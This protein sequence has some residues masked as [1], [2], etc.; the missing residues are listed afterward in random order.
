M[1]VPNKTFPGSSSPA[2]NHAPG[3]R[4][5]TPL[6]GCCARAEPSGQHLT[7]AHLHDSDYALNPRASLS[8]HCPTTS[9]NSAIASAATIPDSR[10]LRR[11]LKDKAHAPMHIRDTRRFISCSDTPFPRAGNQRRASILPW[12]GRRTCAPRN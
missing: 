11:R 3:Q 2:Q 9:C 12:A 4:S 8:R 1:C 6:R 7:S 10:Y 5:L